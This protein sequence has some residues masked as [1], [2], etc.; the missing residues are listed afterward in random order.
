MYKYSFVVILL[1]FETNDKAI[2]RKEKSDTF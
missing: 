1:C 2:S